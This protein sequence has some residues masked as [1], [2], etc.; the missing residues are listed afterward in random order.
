MSS[1]LK[2]RYGIYFSLFLQKVYIVM[3]THNIYVWR[4]HKI[5][6]N[7]FHLC[8][9]NEIVKNVIIATKAIIQR[10]H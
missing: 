8:A 10:V 4:L 6:L 2:D 1:S 5:S 3:N 7:N 9:E